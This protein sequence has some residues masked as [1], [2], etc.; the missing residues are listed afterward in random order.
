[1]VSPIITVSL[2]SVL[3]VASPVAEKSE[4]EASTT[5]NVPAIANILPADT[6]LVGLVNTKVDAWAALSR[7]LFI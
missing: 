3:A 5:L 7:F 4:A 6:P 1:M 2:L